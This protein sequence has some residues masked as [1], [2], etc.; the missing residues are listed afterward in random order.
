M[1][2]ESLRGT[3]WFAGFVALVLYALWA[4]FLPSDL[5]MR[6]GGSLAVAATVVATLYAVRRFWNDRK[7]KPKYGQDQQF[8]KGLIFLL[9]IIVL[10][11]SWAIFVYAVPD[12][13]TR[14]TGRDET[15]ATVLHKV[16]R[17]TRQRRNDWLGCDRRLG[18]EALNR[19][20]RSYLCVT[21]EFYEN[22]PAT[23][24]AVTLEG[25]QSALGFHIRHVSANYTY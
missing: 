13:I 10:V 20:V 5:T 25:P 19:S 3:V 12:I 15:R 18:G 14:A 17:Y 24:S 7:I 22:F 6:W 4:D 16:K 9:P 8:S 11:M 2:T 23:P 1:L 21:P